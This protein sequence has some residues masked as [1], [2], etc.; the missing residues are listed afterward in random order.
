MTDKINKKAEELLRLENLELRTRLTQAE[1]TLDAIRT[2]KAD[3]IIVSGEEGDRIFS[4][5][6][7]ETPYRIF[8]EEMSE[9]A[10]TISDDGTILFC[11]IQ[12]DKILSLPQEK[13]TGANFFL[14]F[15]SNE[16]QKVRGLL[17]SGKVKRCNG[18]ISYTNPG[19]I[20]RTLNL[21][22]FPL[23]TGEIQAVCLIVIDITER[24]LAED[25]LRKNLD[26]MHRFHRLTV[27]R[28][29]KLIELK[30]EINELCKQLG[31][32]ERYTIVG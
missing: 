5:T 17:E 2:G 7:A 12:F 32:D 22:L 14:F 20:I 13:T 9:G 26:E 11:N 27:G 30:K 18:E 6:S 16:R 31:F 3:A 23:Q 8:I 4:L 1:E 25:D 15:N 28:E 29:L 10:A 21:S 24:I 19:G